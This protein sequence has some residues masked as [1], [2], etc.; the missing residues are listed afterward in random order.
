ML[1]DLLQ[2][3]LRESL[4]YLDVGT[5]TSRFHYW[6][7]LYHLVDVDGDISAVAVAL[8]PLKVRF[9]NW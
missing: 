8:W 9:P 1:N 7:R 4:G 5:N 2:V 3:H 6:L